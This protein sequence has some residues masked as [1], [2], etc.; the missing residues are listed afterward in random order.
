MKMKM[1]M[2]MKISDSGRYYYIHA[3]ISPESMP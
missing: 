2:K 1:K 3:T